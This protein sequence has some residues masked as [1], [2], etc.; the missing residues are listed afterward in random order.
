MESTLV[1]NGIF[2]EEN[3]QRY[4]AIVPKGVK[5]LDVNVIGSK[6]CDYIMENWGDAEALCL[7][8][9]KQFPQFVFALYFEQND[10]LINHVF[11]A[12]ARKNTRIKHRKTLQEMALTFHP[13]Y[14]PNYE[15]DFDKKVITE[16]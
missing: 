5:N 13:H 6:C 8:L 4:H 9:E 10:G 15:I 1:L 3:V 7:E 12:I 2:S 11:H 14:R 16:L